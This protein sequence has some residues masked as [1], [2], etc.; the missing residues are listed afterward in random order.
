MQNESYYKS[1]FEYCFKEKINDFYYK[2]R[3]GF[4]KDTNNHTE[5][6]CQII[7][8]A[9]KGCSN[10]EYISL[11]PVKIID[12]FLFNECPSLKTVRFR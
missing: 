12:K 6:I 3:S 10:L 1:K 9:F 2:Q 7:L 4:V 11:P 5:P 8:T